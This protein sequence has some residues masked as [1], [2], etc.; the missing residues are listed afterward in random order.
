MRFVHLVIITVVITIA[1]IIKHFVSHA[2]LSSILHIYTDA[3]IYVVIIAA[4]SVMGK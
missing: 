2:V 4:N 3:K 1:I